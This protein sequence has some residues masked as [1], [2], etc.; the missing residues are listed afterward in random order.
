MASFYDTKTGF[1][2]GSSDFSPFTTEMNPCEEKFIS[3]YNSMIVSAS[4]WRKIFTYSGKEEDHSPQIGPE[5]AA[6]TVCIAESFA[7]YIIDTTKKEH[8]HIVIGI[9]ARPTGQEIADIIIRVLLKRGIKIQYLFITAAP[10]IMAYAR[11]F[12]GFVYVSASHNPVGHNGIKFGFN[13]GG[14]I[15][16]HEAQKLA[17]LF[18]QLCTTDHSAKKAVDIFKEC[19]SVDIDSV[20][21]TSSE[22]KKKAL[23]YYHMF[24]KSVISAETET[25]KQ[26]EF[27]RDIKKSAEQKKITILADMNGSARTV[28]IDKDFFTSLS[29]GYISFN[30]KP[31]EIVHAIIPEPEN[32][33]H[34]ARKMEELQKKGDTSVVLAYMPD[35]D[36]DRGNIVYWNE[37]KQVAQVLK[38]QEVFALS[39][40]SELAYTA[41]NKN[42]H[43][44]EQLTNLR[45]AVSV[46]DPTSM[47]IEEIASAFKASVFRAE[48]GEANV[49]NLARNLRSQGY[50]V[51]I[52]G[53]GSNGGNITHPA[54]VRDPLNTVFALIKL[55]TIKDDSH[56]GKKGLFHL[57]LSLT[58]REY[59]YKDTFTLCDII[60]TLPAF[61][62]TGVSEQRALLTIKTN[63]HSTLKASYQKVFIQEWKKKKEFLRKKFGIESW[64]AVS[65]NGTE[66]TDNVTDFSLSKNGGLKIVLSDIHKTDIAYMWMRGSGTEPVFRVMCDVWGNTDTAIQMEKELLEWHR[67][68][69]ATSDIA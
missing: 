43:S 34:C 58:D 65:N 45:L 48:V 64:R 29:F 33:V 17:L 46:N 40:L 56:R 5:N 21:S 60:S 69:I 51:P 24:T 38:A 66:Q 47:R 52:L 20:Y 27:L 16:A 63:N 19:H 13:D 67:S 22:Y 59:L 41:Y 7:S 2:L 50:L 25:I 28:S 15:P 39:V 49:V 42:A 30:D 3:Q 68:M 8:P 14:V 32:L 26:D 12:D 57:W 54:A 31:R 11:Q 9:D 53:E 1:L 37:K 61:T 55:L 62:T 6:I 44:C 36:G 10:E 18:K 23:S 4:G 35:C